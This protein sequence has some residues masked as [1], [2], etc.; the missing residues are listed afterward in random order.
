MRYLVIVAVVIG[1]SAIAFVLV[2]VFSFLK[3]GKEAT[4]LV[5]EIESELRKNG[6]PARAK[7]VSVIPHRQ[8][9]KFFS[10]FLVLEVETQNGSKYKI[11]KYRPWLEHS[12]HDWLIEKPYIDRI[13]EG[14]VLPIRVHPN[15]PEVVEFEFHIGNEN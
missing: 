3:S 9:K 8:A 5:E 4:H 1:I 13:Q 10:Y 2:K 12:L 6:V 7:I 15:M 11:E 14:A